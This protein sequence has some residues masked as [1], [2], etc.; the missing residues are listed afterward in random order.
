MPDSSRREKG[1]GEKKER[2][3]LAS[4]LKDACVT[5]AWSFSRQAFSRV[6][7]PHSFPSKIFQSKIYTTKIFLELSLPLSLSTLRSH[8]PPTKRNYKLNRT[9]STQFLISFEPI[10]TISKFPPTPTSRKKSCRTVALRFLQSFP[11]LKNVPSSTIKNVP[12]TR[13]WKARREWHRKG[14]RVCST[15]GKE[16]E[17]GKEQ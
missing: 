16:E 1:K 4:V 2:K 8:F 12:L 10:S 5:A 7:N 9:S 3:F 6:R 14:T 15:F 17:G 13:R 11:Q